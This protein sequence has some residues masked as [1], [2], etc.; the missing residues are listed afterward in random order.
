MRRCHILLASA[1][2][3]KPSVLATT[4]HCA[5][6]TVRNV[7]H[8]FDEHGRAWVQHGS[9]AP[10]RGE[11]GLNAAKREQLRAILPQSPRPGGQ[12][13][14]VWTLKRLA[15]VCHEQGLRA[16]LLSAPTLLDAIGRLGGSWQRA[17]PWMARPAPASARKKTPGSVEPTG[18]PP[19]RQRSG[20]RR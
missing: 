18:G 14:S 20:L 12:P 17:K 6:H 1:A 16:T 15:E 8:A 7:I 5:P 4:L 13:A 3:P 9:N 10:V 2:R 19:G 11:P